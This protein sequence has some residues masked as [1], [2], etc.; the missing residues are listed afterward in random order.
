MDVESAHVSTFNVFYLDIKRY[1]KSIIR[2]K[3]I[4][5]YV[6]M[7][8][9]IMCIHVV[10]YV[11]LPQKTDYDVTLNIFSQNNEYSKLNNMIDYDTIISNTELK[12]KYSL[13][14]SLK[15]VYYPLN[16]YENTIESIQFRKNLNMLKKQLKKTLIKQQ[17]DCISAI[18]LGIEYNIVMLN[19]Q[20]LYINVIPLE[21][22]EKKNSIIKITD[23]FN[24]EISVNVSEKVAIEY[25]DES[26]EKKIKVFEEKK[27]SYCLQY[28][29]NTYQIESKTKNEL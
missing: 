9:I 14:N 17:F 6:Y 10:K 15:H 4:T 20:K 28:Y 23:V 29:L 24:N 11:F 27:N 2:N 12:K 3:Y 22:S 16:K 18:S 5:L 25:I 1:F 26:F 7:F 19:D 13:V 8:S 21:N